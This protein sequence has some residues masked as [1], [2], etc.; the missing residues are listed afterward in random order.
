MNSRDTCFNAMRQVCEKLGLAMI[1]ALDVQ[2][3]LAKQYV[4]SRNK[5]KQPIAYDPEELEL[6]YRLDE[7]WV[8]VRQ[9]WA[10]RDH[11]IL[12]Q[13][14]HSFFNADPKEWYRLQHRHTLLLCYPSDLVEQAFSRELYKMD[15]TFLSFQQLLNAA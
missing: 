8:F 12:S 5:A 15:Q 9:V 3:D 14:N 7:L 2:A 11:S 10:N 1:D 4:N 6:L 13:L